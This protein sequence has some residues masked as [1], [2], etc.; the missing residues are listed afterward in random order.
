MNSQIPIPL[1][2]FLV[3]LQFAAFGW[4]VNREITMGDNKETVW[5]PWLDVLNVVSM[6]V[7]IACCLILPLVN[8]GFEKISRTILIV[9]YILVAFHPISMAA[10]YRL[11]FSKGLGKY[12]ATG[13]PK[14][15]DQ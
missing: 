14:T 12:A 13:R 6:L 9:A 2:T 4:R 3:A 1:V 5:I 8:G 7:V 10:H 11:W 15:T